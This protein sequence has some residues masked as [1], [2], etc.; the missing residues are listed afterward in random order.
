MQPNEFLYEEPDP[1]KKEVGH[2]PNYPSKSP[3]L[4]KKGRPHFP[5]IPLVCVFVHGLQ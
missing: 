4:E 5:A 1:L 2:I 3:T